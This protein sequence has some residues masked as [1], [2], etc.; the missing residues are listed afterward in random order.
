MDIVANVVK[1]LTMINWNFIVYGIVAMPLLIILI[2]NYFSIISGGSWTSGKKR[3]DINLLGLA[4]L[5]GLIA[6]TLIWG[7]IFWW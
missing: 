3:F 7:G 2:V 4:S 6:W 5:I 1:I